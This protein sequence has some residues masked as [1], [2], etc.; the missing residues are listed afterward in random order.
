MPEPLT[1]G[2]SPV[3]QNQFEALRQRFLAGLPARWA[4]ILNAAESKSLQLALHRLAGSAGSYGFDRLGQCAREAEALAVSGA[5]APLSA[6]LKVLEAE[7]GATNQLPA[8]RTQL[9][10]PEFSRPR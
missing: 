9:V 6:A 10:Q 8:P 5:S 3:Q 2:L 7:I 1:E 4:E